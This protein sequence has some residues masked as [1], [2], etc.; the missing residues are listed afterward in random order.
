MSKNNRRIEKVQKDSID[1]IN[2]LTIWLGQLIVFSL[3]AD[4]QDIVLLRSVFK[5]RLKELLATSNPEVLKR[6]IF[7]ASDKLCFLLGD[8]FSWDANASQL[9]TSKMKAFLGDFLADEDFSASLADLRVVD[10]WSGLSSCMEG[11]YPMLLSLVD[12]ILE[13]LL[14]VM[15]GDW[16]I[17]FYKELDA[18]F[19]DGYDNLEI[20]GNLERR[21]DIIIKRICFNSYPNKNACNQLKLAILMH[22]PKENENICLKM[23]Y[24]FKTLQAQYKHEEVQ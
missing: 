8:K 9:L 4:Q 12:Y 5:D 19:T 21:L 3:K 1:K 16:I 2:V 11:K 7:T 10:A 23:G 17:P 14:P 20:V 18:L 6:T 24:L 13:I 15:A 22:L